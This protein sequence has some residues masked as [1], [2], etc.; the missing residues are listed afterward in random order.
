MHRIVSGLTGA[1]LWERADYLA[2]R[3]IDGGD[4]DGDGVHDIVMRHGITAGGWTVQ[5]WSVG[6][7][8]W[9][10]QIANPGYGFDDA[11]LGDL[12][13]DGDGVNDYAGFPWWSAARAMITVFSGQTGAVIRT[14]PE[15]AASAITGEDVDL[16]GVPDLVLGAD[17]PVAGT[18]GRTLAFS[19]RDGAELWR[20]DNFGAPPPTSTGTS[21]WMTHAAR[22]SACRSPRSGSCSTRRPRATPRRPDTH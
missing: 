16:D 5:A 2:Q 8:S 13:L 4:I 17:Y 19:G 10:W 11:M 7:S 15:F 22:R 21:G 6:Q 3:M 18:Y 20:V 14:W 12:D 9:L 1:T